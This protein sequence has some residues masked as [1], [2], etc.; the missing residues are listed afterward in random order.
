MGAV[1]KTTLYLPE[2]VHRRLKAVAAQT[3]RT[4]TEVVEEGIALAIA[5]LEH[6]TPNGDAAR[7]R[8]EALWRRIERGFGTGRPKGPRD[9][10]EIYDA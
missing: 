7:R 1:A 5:R 4:M 2:A 9:H 8:R 10:N 6:R 3:S